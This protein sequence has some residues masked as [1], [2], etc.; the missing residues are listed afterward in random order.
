MSYLKLLLIRHA[1]SVGN[2]Q[3]KME[4]QSSTALS[5]RG[6]EQSQQLS[7]A[8]SSSSDL[9]THLYSSPLLRARQT[10]EAIA[11]SLTQAGHTFIYKETDALKEIHAGIFQSL[12][13]AQAEAKYPEL[14]AQLM[15]SM[16][17]QPVPKAE[18]PAMARS[19]AKAWLKHVLS[20]HAAGDVVWCVSHE[21][22]LQHLV[23]VVMG[24]DRTWQIRMAH[25]AIF[26]FW[27][28]CPDLPSL[29]ASTALPASSI[30]QREFLQANYLNNEFW[31]IRRFN[32]TQHL[33]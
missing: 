30:S 31:I 11:H 18:T 9:P 17:W 24:C 14:C 6:Y 29:P 27:L 10:T 8:L 21:G 28:A 12:T 7:E 3:K 4:G 2:V 5:K 23:S 32:D 33:S 20:V 22:F 16:T 25:T 13:W 26:E 15:N 19:R 1:E